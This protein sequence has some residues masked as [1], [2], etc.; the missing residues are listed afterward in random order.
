[1]RLLPGR[2]LA[3]V[4]ALPAIALSAWL[5][6]AFPLLVIGQFT[7]LTSLILGL[8][9]VVAACALVPRLIPDPPAEEKVPWW[10]VVAVLVITVAFAAVQIAFHAEAL[11]IRRDPASYA[12]YTAWIAENG[13]LPIPQQRE[14]IA[15]DDPALSYQSLAYYQRDDVIWPQF[16]AGAPLVLSVGYWLGGLDG[17]LVTTPVLGALGVLTFAGLTARLVGARWAPLSA[18]ILAVCLPQQ[19]VSRFTYS[20]PL[21]QILLLGGL[22]LAF[23]AL[24]RNRS[25]T[26]RWGGPQTLAAVAGL[27]FGLGV[28]VR[29]DAIR[30]LLP[31]VGFIGLLL[32]ARRGQA[33]PLVGGLAVGVIYGLVAG[34]G[35]SYPYLDYLADSLNPLLLISS[36]VVFTTVVLTAA[37]W[38]YG[39][40]HTERVRWLPN[41]M[42]ALA[43]LTMVGFAIRPLLWPDYGH[44]SDFTDQWVAAV[45]QI[46]GLPVE[47]S[48]TYYDMS[49]YWVGWYVGLG[50][51]LFA[52]LGVA[53]VLRRLTQRRDLPWLLPAMLLVWTVTTTLLRPAITPD[54]PWASR[55]LIV[56]VIPAFILFAVW[57]LAWLTRYCERSVSYT[58][59]GSMV[60]SLPAVV[61]A[62]AAVSLLGPAVVTS[63]AGIMGY[64][65]DVGTVAETE[66]LC[67]SLP[68]DAS[69][70][71]VDSAMA[72]N[73]MPL[74]RNVCGVPTA[75]LADPSPEAVH[76]VVSAV[77]ERGRDAVLAAPEWDQ[78]DGLTDGSVETE[79]HFHVVA[80]MDPSTLMEPPT[81][82]WTFNG[83]VW[84]AVLPS[85]E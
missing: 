72:G 17:M 11:V 5:L 39:L 64:R 82:H 66:R 2:I 15:G 10:P 50:T 73:Y 34:Y 1:M 49:L 53:L 27:V 62:G 61:A 48:R 22:L 69:V 31:V 32:V 26:D 9:A 80:E 38:R 45:Q 68:P 29:I 47:G 35:F 30:D 76:R 83:S 46:E 40:P 24:A 20:E 3:R 51:V 12:M 21:A 57:F 16:M 58:R 28:L 79:R 4:T 6:A 14:L 42:A 41:T 81:G 43:L 71:V 33:L 25:I 59:G 8:P 13:Y 44:G 36:V 60:R 70:I 85:P 54:H 56:L 18:L 52:A 75:A 63:A 74:L 78:L 7:P 23:D 65:Q 67:A 19:W 84:T 77:H 37:L 55:R